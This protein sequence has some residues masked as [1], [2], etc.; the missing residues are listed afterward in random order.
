MRED[1]LRDEGRSHSDVWKNSPHRGTSQ[2][3]AFVW[4]LKNVRAAVQGHKGGGE[5]G[6]VRSERELGVR[7]RRDL[8]AS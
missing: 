2:A 3:K 6:K 5:Q 4:E 8:S 1:L 7:P